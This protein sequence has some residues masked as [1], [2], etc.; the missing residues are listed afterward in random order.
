MTLRE[1]GPLPNDG[2]RGVRGPGEGRAG[3]LLMSLPLPE[4]CLLESR[5]RMLGIVPSFENPSRVAA[6]GPASR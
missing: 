4:N 5:L 1:K 2:L 3:F 6:L